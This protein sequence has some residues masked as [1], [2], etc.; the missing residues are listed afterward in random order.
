[1]Y[2]IFSIWAFCALCVLLVFPCTTSHTIAGINGH[3]E[4]TSPL[5]G[6]LEFIK[7]AS[8]T[9]VRTDL[10]WERIEREKGVYN[11]SNSDRMLDAFADANMTALLTVNYGN[12]FYDGGE[13][14][15]TPSG[16]AAYS[17][18]FLAAVERYKGRSIHWEIWNEPNNPVFWSHRL[19]NAHEYAALALTIGRAVKKRFPSEII[20]GPALWLFDYDFVKHLIQEGFLSVID[21][22]SI[23]PYRLGMPEDIL[24]EIP[25]LQELLGNNV[26]IIISEW[27]GIGAD[28][29]SSNPLVPYTYNW[30][31]RFFSRM[32]LCSML[33][34]IH[35]VV[36]YDIHDDGPPGSL[37]FE[38][39]FG[40]GSHKYNPSASLVYKPKLS[41]HAATALHSHFLPGRRLLGRLNTT[42]HTFV[43]EFTGSA[44]AVWSSRELPDTQST[45][46]PNA[47]MGCYS[48]IS[49][50]G[51]SLPHVCSKTDSSLPLQWRDEEAPVFL[52]RINA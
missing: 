1:M 9:L 31:A 7:N 43:L 36:W 19:P 45:V 39:Y 44:Y 6:E 47:S 35:L 46:I 21:L 20:I 40:L 48:C 3:F 18:F 50:T 38:S 17:K 5:P 27:G 30:Q 32:F 49:V 8:F 25:R 12:K 23:H 10:R 2:K 51:V 42:T 11:W 52:I 22:F 29:V 33:A 16:I 28:N 37:N 14:P 34:D 26:S 24:T 41:F 4:G 13:A 15:H